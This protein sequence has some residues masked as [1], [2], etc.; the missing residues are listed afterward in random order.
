M[1]A[2][3]NVAMV[4]KLSPYVNPQSWLWLAAATAWAQ[5]PQFNDGRCARDA[6]YRERRLTPLFNGRDLSGWH[7]MANQPNE[8][9]SPSRGHLSGPAARPPRLAGLG[10]PGDGL[11]T[12]RHGRTVNL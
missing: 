10:G 4:F 2:R 11:L 7:G 3:L 5:P 9:F 6:P 1:P 12:V 8:W